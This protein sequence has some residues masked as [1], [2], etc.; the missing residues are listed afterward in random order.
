M[1]KK[2]EKHENFI[3]NLKIDYFYAIFGCPNE[4]VCVRLPEHGI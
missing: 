4:C 2:N 1:E 3:P